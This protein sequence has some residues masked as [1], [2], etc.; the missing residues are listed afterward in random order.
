MRIDGSWYL[1][2]D[3]VRRPVIRGKVQTRE[4]LWLPTEFLIDTG[5]DRTVFSAVT[6][7]ALHLPTAESRNDLEGVGG[8]ADSVIV[9]TSIALRIEGGADV[10]FR[11]RFA[12][13]T[14]VSALDMSVL[15]RDI[16]NSFAL[17]VDRQN[18]IVCLLGQRHGYV[19]SS[20]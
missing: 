16:I 17:I 18:D 6:L 7:Q 3:G 1:C 13:I 12:A 14:E 8:K 9:E 15:G 19:I 4:A 11:G 5:A 20:D 2:D 10:L